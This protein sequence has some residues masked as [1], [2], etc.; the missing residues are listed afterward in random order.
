MCIELYPEC[1]DGGD[2][3]CEGG[4]KS[5][6][7]TFVVHSLIE[8]PFHHVQWFHPFMSVEWISNF[9]QY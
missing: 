9:T 5:T 7:I 1:G 8:S 3:C 6:S 4:W 2:G